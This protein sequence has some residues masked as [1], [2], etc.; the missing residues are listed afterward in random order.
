V[1]DE[2]AVVGGATLLR[3]VECKVLDRLPTD[4]TYLELGPIPILVVRGGSKR[5][6]VVLKL[7]CSLCFAKRWVD[8]QGGD[9][10]LI[11]SRYADEIQGDRGSDTVFA[12][13]GNDTVWG[14]FGHN[15]LL[16][17][18]DLPA[19][20]SPDNDR[21]FGQGGQDII[22]GSYGNDLVA[23]GPDDDNLTMQVP[24]PDRVVPGAYPGLPD[25][26]NV[27]LHGGAGDD[28]VIGGS[29]RDTMEGG[30]DRDTILAREAD[31]GEV[32]EPDEVADCG[33]NYRRP[34]TASEY[35][36][37]STFGSQRIDPISAACTREL[38][39]PVTWST[40][41]AHLPG[42]PWPWYQ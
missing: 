35:F 30:S 7:H 13:G 2:D 17:A 5:D 19:D 28:V 15:S 12:G 23:G 41:A 6:T 29:G 33:P 27:A 16:N 20:T 1:R 36:R 40:L 18:V 24:A 25:Y 37:T 9:D 42:D 11:G 31:F 21:L 22:M 10:I 38:A 3:T 32:D 8:G 4:P 26:V 34:V 14:Y 39:A